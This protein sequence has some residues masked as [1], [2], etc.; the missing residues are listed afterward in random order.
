MLESSLT[1]LKSQKF[2]KSKLTSEEGRW[3]SAPTIAIINIIHSIIALLYCNNLHLGITK[4]T[5]LTVAYMH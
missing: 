4:N 2:L 1:D 5:I 3:R